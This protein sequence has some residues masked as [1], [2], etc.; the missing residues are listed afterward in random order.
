MSPATTFRVTD[1]ATEAVAERHIRRLTQLL[2]VPSVRASL[3]LA[4]RHET[5]RAQWQQAI[6]DAHS[7]TARAGDAR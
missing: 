1:A 2:R 5:E 6:N 4:E 3:H 7:N